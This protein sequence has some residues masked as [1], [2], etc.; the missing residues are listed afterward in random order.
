MSII[1]KIERLGFGYILNNFDDT[2]NY[3]PK[4][5][6]RLRDQYIQLWHDTL[7]SQTKMQYYIKFKT[8]FEYEKYLDAVSNENYRQEMSRFRLSSHRLEIESGRYNNVVRADRIC[9]VCTQNVVESEYHFLLCCSL[10][11]EFRIKYFT[12]MSWVS[13]NKF[14][15][16]LSSK[17]KKVLVNTATFIFRSMKLRQEILSMIAAS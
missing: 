3:L 17:N 9:K 14:A 5:K 12:N 7:S 16:I 6:Q 1:S 15:N 2:I 13:L 8:V 11:R 10:Y 4:L